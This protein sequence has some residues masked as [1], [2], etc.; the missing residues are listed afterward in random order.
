M[1]G[2]NDNPRNGKRLDTWKEIGG[3]FGRDERTVKRWEMT[4]KLPVHRVPGG[5]RANVYAYEGEL[6]EWL[7]SNDPQGDSGPEDAV[8]EGGDSSLAANSGT[9]EAGVEAASN[10][11][12]VVGGVEDEEKRSW[13]GSGLILIVLVIVAVVAGLLIYKGQ[14]WWGSGGTASSAH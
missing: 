6:T 4:R 5:G 13:G 1:T 14:D 3:F 2:S 10:G 11:A 8:A 12:R 7:R 9:G